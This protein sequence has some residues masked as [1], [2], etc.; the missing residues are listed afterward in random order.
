MAETNGYVKWKVFIWT[1]SIILML[2]TATWGM[3]G[4][5]M[6]KVDGTTGDIIEM[7]IML[8]ELQTDIKWIKH[9]LDEYIL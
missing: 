2:F 1:V 8:Q 9:E 5:A 6:S 3:I 4:T 7:K